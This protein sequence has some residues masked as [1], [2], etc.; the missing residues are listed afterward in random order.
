MHG[1]PTK[2]QQMQDRHLVVAPDTGRQNRRMDAH[3][4]HTRREALGVILDRIEE[5]MRRADAWDAEAPPREL[6]RSRQPFCY[7]TL[8]F[9]QWVQWQMIPRMRQILEHHEELPE[10]SA[11]LPYAEEFV[12]GEK[13]E[14][15]R[16]LLRLIER[17]DELISG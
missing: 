5:T 10:S 3:E 12:P 1:G 13:D 8:T 4:E 6:L 15:A 14:D 9:L 11:I 17:F 7:D 16:E 2:A